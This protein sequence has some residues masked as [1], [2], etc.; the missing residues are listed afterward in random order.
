MHR[1]PP[2]GVVLV[3]YG[4]DL[5]ELE[6]ESGLRAR[7]EVVLVGIVAEEGPDVTED[8]LALRGL[9]LDLLSKARGVGDAVTLQVLLGGLLHQEVNPLVRYRYLILKRN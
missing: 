2:V 8:A 9:L 5:P 3:E 4:Q 6:V 1:L 7:D